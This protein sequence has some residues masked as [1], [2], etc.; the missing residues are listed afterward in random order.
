MK[1]KRLIK[2]N[3]S[4]QLFNYL[5]NNNNLINSNNYYIFIKFNLHLLFVRKV[6]SCNIQIKTELNQNNNNKKEQTNNNN[7]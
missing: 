4:H 5:Y 2:N 6:H 1:E 7:I 3:N